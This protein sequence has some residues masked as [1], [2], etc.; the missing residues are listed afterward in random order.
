MSESNESKIFDTRLKTPF[1]AIASGITGC[2]KSTF[3]LNL[4]QMRDQVTDNKNCE[5]VIYYFNQNQDRFNEIDSS[6]VTKWIQGMPTK[7]EVEQEVMPYKNRGGS[8][9]VIDDFAHMLNKDTVEIFTVLS[10]HANASIILISQNLFGRSDQFRE[11]SLNVH[12]MF[13]FKN[14]RDKNQISVLARQV[15]PKN[16]RSIVESFMKAT[17]SPYSYL[18]FDSRQETPDEI[19]L[20]SKILPHES[21]MVVYVPPQ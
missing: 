5:N 16:W 12:Y 17:K 21:P 10:H 11:I 20:R 2:G 19:R 8:I 7:D 3:V 1:T 18:L 9:V 6:V 4:L 14:P 15:D 13:V